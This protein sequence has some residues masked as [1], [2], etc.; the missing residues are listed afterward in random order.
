LAICFTANADDFLEKISIETT[1]PDYKKYQIRF[2]PYPKPE[3]PDGKI[4]V[5]LFDYE[6]NNLIIEEFQYFEGM[7]S[8]LGNAVAVAW[9]TPWIETIAESEEEKP[10]V[11]E[12][13]SH[14][15]VPNE[16]IPEISNSN[17]GNMVMRA[18]WHPKVI[19]PFL[20]FFREAD[21]ERTAFRFI[22]A[23]FSAYFILVAL[24][25]I[26]NGEI[27]KFAKNSKSLRISPM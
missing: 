3:T 14:S 17:D 19:N 5:I 27:G 6:F 16:R 10:H 21:R 20:A 2:D 15:R 8:L 12:G 9:Q 4:M 26:R 1:D 24:M 18:H 25:E 11:I 22:N 7:L 13:I 23:F